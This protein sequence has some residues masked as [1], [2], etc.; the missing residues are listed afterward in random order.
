MVIIRYQAGDLVPADG[1]YALVGHFGEASGF[2]VWRR[3]G[4]KLPLAV[5]SEALASPLWFVQVAD[6]AAIRTAA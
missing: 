2:A 4:E 6:E 3:K 5:V 1:M